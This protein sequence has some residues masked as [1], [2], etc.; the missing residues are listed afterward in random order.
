[1]GLFDALRGR[2]QRSRRLVGRISDEPQLIGQNGVRYLV[3]HVAEAPHIEF[4]LT[5]LPT[6]QKRRKGDRVELTWSR[7]DGGVAILEGLYA[8]PDWESVKRRNE[9]YL[10]D[11]Q[12]REAKDGH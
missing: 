9:T 1:M 12:A 7:E 10:Q 3:F 8:A 5:M 4:R 2:G 6:T 11:I